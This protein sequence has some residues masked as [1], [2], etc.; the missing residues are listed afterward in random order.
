VRCIKNKFL[1]GITIGFLMIILLL[2]FSLQDRTTALA[3]EELLVITGEGVGNP[4]TLDRD[5]LEAMEQHEYIYSAVNTWPTKK[6][7]VGRGVHLEE[8]LDLAGVKE[9]ATLIKLTSSDGYSI[10]LTVKEVLED[11]RYC[12]PNFKTGDG[13]GDGN[14]AG[15][16]AGAQLVEPIIAL[17]SVEGS[18][19]PR[20]MNDL[21]TP[22]LM[23]GQR[24]VTEQTGNLFV[25]YLHKIEVLTED[26]PQW[27]APQANPSSGEVS[28]GTMIA[29]SN[30]H[31]DDDKVYYTTDGSTPDLNSPMYNWIARRWWASRADVLGLYNKPIGP[32]TEDTTI[33]A[34]TIGPGKADSQVV[35]F[36]YTLGAVELTETPEE[37]AII[38]LND[39]KGHWAE[40]NIMELV[41]TGSVG[42]YPDG[43]FKP[44]NTITRAEFVCMLVKAFKL[45]DQGGKTFADTDRH[46]AKDYIATAT[47]HGLVSGYNDLTFGPDDL[48]NREQMAVMIF[49]AAKLSAKSGEAGFADQQKISSWARE[50]VAAVVDSGIMNGYQDNTIQPQGKANRAEA[51]TV[52]I[53]ALNR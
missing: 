22:L 33:K 17:V 26:I 37:P 28:A 36:T 51:A 43:S 41:A 40:K 9:E 52:I 27:D 42:G 13:D 21:S 2:G 19:N 20:Y 24:A 7:Y 6:W 18:N 47:S 38:Y 45:E 44:G 48:I 25:K 23:L 39:I 49:K 14:I 1:Y 46:W 16:A 11:Q 3:G 8:L 50:A 15:S 31:M 32:L 35:S 4:L 53:K 5:E 34:V 12:F 10:S 29:L 30:A